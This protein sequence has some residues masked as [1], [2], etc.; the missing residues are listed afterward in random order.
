MPTTAPNATAKSKLTSVSRVSAVSMIRN[1]ASIPRAFR[2]SEI[3]KFLTLEA[4][5]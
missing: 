1:Y 4:P 2:N 3:P 5:A